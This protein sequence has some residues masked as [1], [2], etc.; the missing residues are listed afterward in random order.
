M[1]KSAKLIELTKIFFK[2][3]CISFGGPA[4][5]IA[6]MQ[7]EIVD[8]R[9]WIDQSEFLD[10]IGATNLIP[11]PNSTQM[12]MH[13]GHR[14]AGILGVLAAGTAFIFPAFLIT[15]A[16]AYCYVNYGQH[17][18]FKPFIDGIK[19]AV[20]ALIFVTLWKLAQ[21]A[22][23]TKTLAIIAAA[24][25]TATLLGLNEFIAIL[26][27]GL[28]GMLWL[29]LTSKNKIKNSTANLLLATTTTAISKKSIAVITATTATAL[30]GVSLFKLGLFFLKI[31]AVLYGSGYVLIA[32]IEGG[33][34]ND[35]GWLTQQQLLDSVAIGQLTPGPVLT[36]ATVVGYILAGWKG[37]IVA[38][39]A[40]FLPSFILVSILSP[41]I[42]KIRKFPLASHFL[43]AINAC[44]VGL[45]AAVTF[46]LT[47]NSFTNWPTWLIAITAAI[48]S[49]KF[50]VGPL[51][52]VLGG[53]IVGYFLI[54]LAA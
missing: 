37:A 49:I 32:Y 45:M 9:K 18:N 40:I 14:R 1:K 46:S 35:L 26:A 36:T 22:I 25:I 17:P 24:V 12:T 7:S 28:I 52:L 5:H 8:K 50:K 42:P 11:G 48:A 31:A 10:M 27:G 29:H 51:W 21:K 20:L 4:A 16:F 13:I 30:T 54:P 38:T 19:P 43:D 47:T 44:S 53:A 34:V 6:M 33:L 39:L 41:V 15:L 2:L 3:G 23:K